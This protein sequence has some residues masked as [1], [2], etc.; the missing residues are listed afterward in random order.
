MSMNSG[1]KL[2]L[3]FSRA[4]RRRKMP[5]T[6]VPRHA[7]HQFQEDLTFVGPESPAGTAPDREQ[8]AKL[9][10]QNCWRLYSFQNIGDTIILARM[11]DYTGLVSVENIQFSVTQAARCFEVDRQ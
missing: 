10:F 8:L 3:V 4:R 6:A 9:P 2:T 11:I 5:S 7:R 1:H